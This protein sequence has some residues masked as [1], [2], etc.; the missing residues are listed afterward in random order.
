MTASDLSQVVFAF[1]AATHSAVL[2]AR[3]FKKN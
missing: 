1:A 3:L 2:A